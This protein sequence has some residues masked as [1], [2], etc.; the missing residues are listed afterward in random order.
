MRR[1]VTFA[2]L[3]LVLTGCGEASAPQTPPPV[4]PPTSADA[5]SEDTPSEEP[6]PAEAPA[7]KPAPPEFF[8]TGDAVAG[9][10]TREVP[11]SCGEGSGAGPWIFDFAVPATWEENGK[12]NSGGGF[13]GS[14][15]YGDIDFTT[16][17]GLKVRIKVK[18]D[19]RDFT[20][21][22]VGD[23]D[24]VL[25]EDHFDYS[26]ER[27]IGDEPMQ[28]INVR[29]E[30]LEPVTI[31]GKQVPFAVMDQ[32]ASKV[33]AS[34]Y[35]SRLVYANVP[36]SQNT[37]DRMDWSATVS[38]S[39]DSEKGALEQDAAR[40]LLESFRVGQ[41]SQDSGVEYVKMFGITEFAE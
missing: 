12:G 15:G 10:D 35:I 26:F 30:A 8:F 11:A 20:G 6:E 1:L 28:T 19:G 18:Q 23:D 36:I 38:I 34:E 32:K 25:A 9:S 21:Q 31:D 7:Q 3:A 27:A 17:D 29:Y 2:V 13:T 16:A 39:W 33:D 40:T 24:Q 4:A 41:C 22:L 37:N 14:G 5:P